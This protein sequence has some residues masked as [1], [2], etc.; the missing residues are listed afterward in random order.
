M[1]KASDYWILR[2]I[3]SIGMPGRKFKL[4][5]FF[6]DDNY[7]DNQSCF[8]T[9]FGYNGTGE[10][11]GTIFRFPLRTKQYNSTIKPDGVYSAEKVKTV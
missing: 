2:S 5:R 3:Y 6:R 9:Y 11:D 4:S 8:R 10:Y 1:T 7:S